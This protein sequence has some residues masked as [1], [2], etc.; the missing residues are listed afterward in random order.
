MKC[1][2]LDDYQNIGLSLVDWSPIFS[3][4]EIISF[5]EHFS[6]VDDLVKAIE[7]FEIVIIM[8]ERTR[9]H[10]DVLSRL[11]KLKLL[12]TTGM[13]NSAIDL[14]TAQAQG[15]VVCGTASSS[16]PPA[17]LTWTLIL[18]L[19]KNIHKEFLAFKMDGPWQQALGIGLRGRTLGLLGLGKIGTEVARI[20]QAFGM[21]VMAWSE[22]LTQDKATSVNVKFSSSKEELLQQSD[23]VSVHLRASER[24]KGLI[25]ERELNCMRKTAFLI[26]TSRASIVNENALVKALQNNWIAGVGLDVFSEEPLPH[27]HIMRTLPN[28]VATP[29]LGYVSDENYFTYFNE[30]LEDIQAYLAGRPVR[31][32]S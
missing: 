6:V 29:H 16:I 11:P 31:T 18:C 9:F 25:G 30:A 23:F 7:D 28:V 5:A 21:D 15:V 19:A 26:N 24:T 12:I 13:R 32:L 3:E 22:N 2:I 8:R 17:E 20:G 10:A 14:Q 1:A 27:G 4:V